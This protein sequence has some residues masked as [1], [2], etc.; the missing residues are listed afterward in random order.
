VRNERTSSNTNRIFRLIMANSKKPIGERFSIFEQEKNSRN[1]AME[2]LKLL[3]QK[4][5]DKNRN[6]K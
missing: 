3:K 2:M 6:I 4:E 5:N 1:K